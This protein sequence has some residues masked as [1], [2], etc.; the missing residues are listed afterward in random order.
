MITLKR[1][2]KID[3]LWGLFAGIMAVLFCTFLMHCTPV[4]VNPT[5][6]A[7]ASAT[8]SPDYVEAGVQVATGACT[9][10]QG[11]TQ[12]QTVISICATIEEVAQIATFIGSFLRHGEIVDAGSCTVLPNSR[13]CATPAELG[14]AISFVVTKRQSLFMLDGGTR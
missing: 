13:V 4:P 2:F 3:L 10:L 8:Q 11:I 7:D 9:F 12:N 6:D 1:T 5:H 14:K